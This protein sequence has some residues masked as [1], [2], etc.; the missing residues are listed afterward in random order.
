MML[1]PSVK[2]LRLPLAV[3]TLSLLTAQAQAPGD[4]RVALVIGNSSY[5]GAP[6][7]NPAN[8]ARAMSETLRGLGFTV[9]ELR[10]GGRAQMA[11]AIAKVRESLKGKQGVGMLYYAGHGLQLDWHNYMVPVDARLSQAT[12]VPAQTIDINSVIDAF[13]GA[14]NRMNILVLDACRDNP[15]TDKASGKGLAQLDAPPGTFLAYATAPGNV[16]ED[17]DVQSG[18]GLYTQFL[19]AELKKPTAKIEDVFKRVRLQVRQKSQGRQIPWESTSLEDDF[20]FNDG[21]KISLKAEDLERMAA[22]ARELQKLSK[23][24]ADA[25]EFARQKADWDKIRDSKNADDF[26]AYLNKYP[27]GLISEQANAALER[28]AEAKTVAV[29]DR[30]GFIQTAGGGR[31]R[32][33]DEATQ[34]RKDMLTG[35]EIGRGRLVVTRIADGLVE[36]NGGS[37]VLTI[38]G[39]VIRNN[40]GAQFDPPRM[41]FPG[42]GFAVGKKWTAHTLQTND[43]GKAFRREDK[44]KIVAVEDITVPAGT[45]KAY[46]FEMN[47][48][49]DN[50]NV[51]K[52]TY[53]AQPDFPFPIKMQREIRRRKGGPTVEVLEMTSRKRGPAPAQQVSLATGR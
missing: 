32:L 36:M 13:K 37:T 33:G 7:I 12:D 23:D 46:R 22:E 30:N 5:A 50:G 31:F 53:W 35:Q 26:Y 40:L 28:L 45:F 39:A 1:L 10:D 16:A 6:L 4:V 38:D 41:D 42:D 3:L 14:G 18:N 15:F 34:V 25:R 51:V 52:L 43:K 21:A 2:L 19:L 8:D 24:E 44:V 29:A 47:S 27:N 17:G 9:V 49:Q 20:V 11:E 48:I